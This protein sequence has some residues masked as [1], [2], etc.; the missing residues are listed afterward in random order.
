MKDYNAI[1]KRMYKDTSA[2]KVCNKISCTKCPLVSAADC[3]RL[4]MR[5]D[6]NQII[7]NVEEWDAAHPAK[8]YAQDFFE[9]F[10]HVPVYRYLD[11]DG[12]PYP[13]GYCACG[14][15]R[16]DCP[17]QDALLHSKGNSKSCA[18]CWNTPMENNA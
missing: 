3:S 10:P 13:A 4:I 7:K 1:L 12:L 15:Y 5:L 18:R 17:D 9:K 11:M 6:I 8:T 16:D 2:I 14:L